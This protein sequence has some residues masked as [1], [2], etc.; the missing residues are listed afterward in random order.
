MAGKPHRN[1]IS[2][3]ISV[4]PQTGCWNWTGK[5][6]PAG[7]GLLRR[8]GK[9]KMAHR[10][11]Y[12]I[13]CGP[14]PLGL[15][16]DHLCRNPRCVNPVHL[17]AVTPRENVYRGQSP[18]ILIMKSGRCKRGHEMTPENSYYVRGGRSRLCRTCQINW[19]RERRAQQKREIA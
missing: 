6:T 8:Q 19:H 10:L 14:I 11:V 9:W 4:D 16:L 18:S 5:H 3:R 13:V 15:H 2:A 12:E 17:E 7:Y 1:S